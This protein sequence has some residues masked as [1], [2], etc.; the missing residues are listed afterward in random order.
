M[1]LEV[2]VAVEKMSWI[3]NTSINPIK[4]EKFVERH[5]SGSSF[6]RSRSSFGSETDPSLFSLICVQ[7]TEIMLAVLRI[8]IWDPDKHSRSAKESLK[9]SGCRF[10]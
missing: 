2:T 3:R 7:R 8:R 6:D 9:T 1:L 5:R 4:V 10:L